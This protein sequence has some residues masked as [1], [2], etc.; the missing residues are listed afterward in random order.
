[1]AERPTRI[2]QHTTAPEHDDAE[3]PSTVTLLSLAITTGVS[4]TLWTI[5]QFDDRFTHSRWTWLLIIVTITSWPAYFVWVRLIQLRLRVA[6]LENGTSTSSYEDV[7][8]EAY[9]SGFLAGVRAGRGSNA[10]EH[11]VPLHLVN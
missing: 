9:A 6:H 10:G 3:R 1:V 5:A 7:R 2:E 4:A 8:R 11:T